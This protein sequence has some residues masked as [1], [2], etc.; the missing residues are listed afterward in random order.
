MCLFLEFFQSIFRKTKYFLCTNKF[1]Q[2]MFSQKY[3]LFEPVFRRDKFTSRIQKR[4]WFAGGVARRKRRLASITPIDFAGNKSTR[5]F[6]PFLYIIFPHQKQYYRML[7]SVPKK[8]TKCPFYMGTL[9][10]KRLDELY[11]TFSIHFL[12][13]ETVRR[14]VRRTASSNGF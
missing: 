14:F 8:I 10:Q 6:V 9:V 7:E 2:Y 5:Y 13:R 12:E 4:V 11:R 3:F 1:C